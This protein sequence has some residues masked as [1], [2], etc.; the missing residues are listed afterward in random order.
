MW[1]QFFIKPLMKKDS[2]DREMEAVDS[3]F[4]NFKTDDS[5]RKLQI[6][7]E[8][9]FKPNHPMANFML[10]NLVSLKEEQKANGK[11]LTYKFFTADTGVLFQTLMTPLNVMPATLHTA[12]K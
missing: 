2:V 10:G 7:Q 12:G 5:S 1:S 3:E 6:I 11:Q 4:N 9:I 8:C